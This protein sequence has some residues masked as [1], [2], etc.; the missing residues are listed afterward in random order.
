MYASAS[1]QNSNITQ[2]VISYTMIATDE[3]LMYDGISALNLRPAHSNPSTT[4]ATAIITSAAGL[5]Q[6]CYPLLCNIYTVSIFHSPH[7][8][9]LTSLFNTMHTPTH[10]SC[11]AVSH[12][13]SRTV[14]SSRYMVLLRKSIPIVAYIYAEVMRG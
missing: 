9:W 14:R 7:P 3:S 8:A 6:S 2:L 1:V 5:C 4:E 11:P 10:L 12:S 13:C